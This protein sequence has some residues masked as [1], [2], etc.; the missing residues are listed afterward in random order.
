MFW[1]VMLKK[2]EK[3]EGFFSFDFNLQLYLKFQIAEVLEL[4][5]GIFRFKFL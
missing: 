3:F 1:I 5:G 2:V 4:Y